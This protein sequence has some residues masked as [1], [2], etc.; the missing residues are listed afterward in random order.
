MTSPYHEGEFKVVAV[1][2]T[3]FHCKSQPVEDGNED[4][5]KE[6]TDKVV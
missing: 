4:L 2:R 1:K 5:N 6:T 3:L